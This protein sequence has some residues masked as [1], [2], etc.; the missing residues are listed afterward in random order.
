MVVKRATR[1]S[2]IPAEG[3][4]EAEADLRVL[5]PILTDIRALYEWRVIKIEPSRDQLYATTS[6]IRLPVS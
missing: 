6:G 2:A 3:S 1:G 4:F 5:F